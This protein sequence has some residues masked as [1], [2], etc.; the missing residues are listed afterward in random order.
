MRA[1]RT[2]APCLVNDPHLAAAALLGFALVFVLP[3]WSGCGGEPDEPAAPGSPPAHRPGGPPPPGPPGGDHRPMN[4]PAGP[5]D[6]PI[7]LAAPAS[8]ACSGFDSFTVLMDGDRVVDPA[9]LAGGSQ[10]AALIAV[11]E[12]DGARGVLLEDFGDFRPALET[13]LGQALQRARGHGDIAHHAVLVSHP[14]TVGRMLLPGKAPPPP[15][16]GPDVV[17]TVVRELEGPAI[18]GPNLDDLCTIARAETQWQVKPVCEQQFTDLPVGVAPVRWEDGTASARVWS[19]TYP[20][21]PP[22]H[23]EIPFQPLESV[24]VVSSP[25]GYLVYAV[26][27]HHIHD[28]TG[29]QHSPFHAAYH[30]QKAMD[31]GLLP[32]GPIHTLI[33]GTCGVLRTYHMDGGTN[34]HGQFDGEGFQRR[35]GVMQR[36]LGVQRLYLTHCGVGPGLRHAWPHFHAALGAQVRLAFPGTCIPLDGPPGDPPGDGSP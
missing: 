17:T 7:A 18:Q 10:P 20:I 12:P 35:I 6:T 5:L 24:L 14:H 33:T 21:E 30:V 23:G 31:D 27:S 3:W 19:L 25:P 28:P 22:E 29:T 4:P 13:N 15:D 36:E 16:Q 11:T 1:P 8:E 2:D 32:A 34:A 26:C 9:F